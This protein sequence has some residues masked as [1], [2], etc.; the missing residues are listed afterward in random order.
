MLRLSRARLRGVLGGC[1]TFAGRLAERIHSDDLVG[2]LRS[3]HPEIGEQAIAT[4]METI[5]HGGM[6]RLPQLA[7]AATTTPTEQLVDLLE[8]VGLFRNLRRDA[9]ERLARRMFTE[10]HEAGF[11]F[12]RPGEA[13]DRIYVIADGDVALI[14]ATG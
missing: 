4:W 2:N 7:A 13:A 8:D 14:D 6:I 12:F 9:L 3:S 10:D 5:D 1:P 11:V